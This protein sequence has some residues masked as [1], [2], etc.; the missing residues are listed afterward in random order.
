MGGFPVTAVGGRAG[1]AGPRTG[2]SQPQLGG[3]GYQIPCETLGAKSICSQFRVYSSPGHARSLTVVVFGPGIDLTWGQIWGK[4]LGF[5]RIW[6][7]LLAHRCG[8]QGQKGGRGNP[9]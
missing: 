7:M 4:D 5:S 1:V 6:E 3:V 9:I 2:T 8:S